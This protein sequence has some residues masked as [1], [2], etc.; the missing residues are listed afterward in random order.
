MKKLIPVLVTA[1]LVILGVVMILLFSPEIEKF[2]EGISTNVEAIPAI[3]L[4]NFSD[5]R[6]K[7]TEILGEMKRLGYQPATE[8]EVREWLGVRKFEKLIIV[9]DLDH[10]RQSSS[11]ASPTVPSFTQFPERNSGNLIRRE[12]VLPHGP[13]DDGWTGETYR[14]TAVPTQK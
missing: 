2:C 13:F 9:C 5:Q 7:T 4:F 8:T 1:V 14:F 11:T 6:I 10:P 3:K 12:I